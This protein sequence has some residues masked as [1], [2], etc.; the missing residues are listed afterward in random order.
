MTD[1]N[2]EN[3]ADRIRTLERRIDELEEAIRRQNEQLEEELK[4]MGWK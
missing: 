4:S 2:D 1:R 3:T